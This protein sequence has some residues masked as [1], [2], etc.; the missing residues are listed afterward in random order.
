MQFDSSPHLRRGGQHTTAILASAIVLVVLVF[1]LAREIVL[2]ISAD[3]G[4]KVNFAQP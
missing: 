4:E 1:F 2:K 3:S